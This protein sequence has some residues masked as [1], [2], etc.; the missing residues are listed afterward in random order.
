M[1]ADV[2]GTTVLAI[3][4]V[5][6][7]PKNLGDAFETAKACASFFDSKILAVT[8]LTPAELPWPVDF[9]G[10][11]SSSFDCFTSGWLDEFLIDS[12]CKFKSETVL[13]SSG[14]ISEAVGAVKDL[15]DRERARALFVITHIQDQP[16]LFGGFVN[17]LVGSPTMPVVAINA[18]ARSIDK[19]KKIVF[20]TDFSPI[21]DLALKSVLPL[22][23]RSGAEIF[24]LHKLE[25][26]FVEI[27]DRFGRALVEQA[28]GENVTAWFEESAP[29][30]E[31]AD[32]LLAKVEEVGADLLVLGLKPRPEFFSFSTGLIPELLRR[33]QCPVL[34]LTEEASL[35]LLKA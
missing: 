6:S 34:L 25:S 29:S 28:R 14:Q 15:A 19:V 7:E 18:K 20:A 9:T 30:T 24:L 23:A 3:D 2:S 27:A 13:N 31:I 1:Q 5:I 4:S 10:T 35:S 33:S 22:A 32:A 16:H 26:R 17:R 11:H 12:N 8:V 21:S